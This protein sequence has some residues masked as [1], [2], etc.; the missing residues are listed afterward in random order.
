MLRVIS[1]SLFN[2]FK[3][4]YTPPMLGRWSLDHTQQMINIKADMTNE[5]HCGICDKMRLDYIKD[6]EKSI[7]RQKIVNM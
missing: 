4:K 7:D 2:V 5:D 6:E 3:N 1:K